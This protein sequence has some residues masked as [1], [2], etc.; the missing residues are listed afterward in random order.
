MNEFGRQKNLK[1]I[2]ETGLKQNFFK[3]TELS[4]NMKLMLGRIDAC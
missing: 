3:R 2:E 1:Y 4:G